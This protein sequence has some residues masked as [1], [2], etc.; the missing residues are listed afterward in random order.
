MKRVFSLLCIIYFTLS[1]GSDVVE[2][3]E[4]KPKEVQ[5]EVIKVIQKDDVE[6]KEEEKEIEEIKEENTVKD[7]ENSDVITHV[8]D[9]EEI[10]ENGEIKYFSKKLNKILESSDIFRTGILNTLKYTKD[11]N[12][13]GL[14][15]N[16]FILK[17][18]Y[19]L[20]GDHEEVKLKLDDNKSLFKSGTELDS[21]YK[22]EKLVP[23]KRRIDP[24]KK[25]IAFTFD[26][27]P[28]NKNHVLIR[29]L[30][31]KYDETATFFFVGSSVKKHP[32]M[33]LK[34][35][36]DG[37][38]IGNHTYNHPNLRNL[39]SSEIW[40]EISRTNDEI[41]KIIGVDGEYV[42]PPYGAFNNTVVN[43]IGGKRKVALWNVDS[44]D[45]KSRNVDTIISRVL[46][47][48]K[49]GD[50]VLFHDLYK[51]SYESVSI[52]LPI[53]KERGF[54]FVSYSEMLELRK[55]KYKGE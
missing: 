21:I 6:Q 45:W 5:Q 36:L 50:I 44:E 9:L 31:N 54:Q 2:K 55:N 18:G 25:H 7:I 22:G 37:H 35:Y 19:I 32:E 28:G 15:I 16:K 40:N 46:D 47:K 10:N 12:I 38:E 52:M 49:D 11:I 3:K 23:K 24:N 41:F 1:C 43:I 42:R 53:L 27:G 39:N 51:E 17:D 13:D 14:N 8:Y 48:V 29:E 4:E 26:D 33:V 20:I 34:T 30:F